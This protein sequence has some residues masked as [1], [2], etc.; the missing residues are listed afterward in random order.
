MISSRTGSSWRSLTITG[1]VLPS[2]FR[3]ISARAVDQHVAQD[4]RVHLERHGVLLAR[5]AVDHAGDDALAAHAARS[6]GAALG[7]RF[8]FECG[9]ASLGHRRAQ[10]S[11]RAPMLGEAW[12]RDDSSIPKGTDPAHRAGRLGGRHPGRP[13]RGHA[14]REPRALAE[15]AADALE[16]RHLEAA[17]RMVAT[18]GKMKGAAMK[19]G[20]LASFIDTE[21]L[22]PEYRELYQEQLA[23]LRTQA[24]TM[25]W[26]QVQQGAR[27]GVGGALRGAVRGLRARGRGGGFDRPGAP[28]G[29]A[30]RAAGGGEDPVPGRGG[31][32]RRRH[33]ERRAD[34]ADGQGA[35]ARAR[36]QGGRRGAARSA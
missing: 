30:R 19:I 17:E 28:R 16:R 18:L 21:F 2:T 10:C 11:E 24:P 36:R 33:A 14:R 27:G 12:L 34:P 7:A 22:P 15:E 1:S 23:K 13:L 3:S 26:K 25:P 5:P 31:G 9:S 32:D 8:D 4:A 35:R 20:Q 6:A 29:A